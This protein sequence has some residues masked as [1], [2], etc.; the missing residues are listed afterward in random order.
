ME[1]EWG[2]RKEVRPLKKPVL[3]AREQI[4]MEKP[5]FSGVSNGASDRNKV[6]NRLMLA[7]ITLMALL[8]SGVLTG[9]QCL[10]LGDDLT[11]E[12]LQNAEYKL[13]CGKVKLEDGG[14]GKCGESSPYC[15]VELS[16]DNIAFGDLNGD[17]ITDAVAIFYSQFG[18][19]RFWVELVVI[20]RGEGKPRQVAYKML[21]KNAAVKS[22]AIKSG[23]IVLE[24][25]KYA[26]DDP[27]CCP[28]LSVIHKYRLAG[29]N[30]VL[31]P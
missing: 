6:M 12:K 15:C 18:Y 16:A 3:S 24:L 31:V 5:D 23:E 26:P 19:R 17:G 25:G 7:L 30:L 2:R 14:G 4:S 13:R 8:G 11:V 21:G 10:A 9:E 20:T 29:K 27:L 1:T 28:S 22:I